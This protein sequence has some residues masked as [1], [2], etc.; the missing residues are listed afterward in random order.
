MWSCNCQMLF[1]KHQLQ[2]GNHQLVLVISLMLLSIQG[3]ILQFSALLIPA[4][5]CRLFLELHW[6]II[7]QRLHSWDYR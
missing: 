2:S 5:L 7:K 3:S 6:F 4:Q 1:L